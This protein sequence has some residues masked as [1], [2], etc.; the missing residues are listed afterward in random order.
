MS[1]KRLIKWAAIALGVLLVLLVAALLAAG[2]VMKRIALA[3]IQK[4]T[5]LVPTIEQFDYSPRTGTLHISGF[6]LHEHATNGGRLVVDLPELH[7]ELEPAADGRREL[8]F[9]EIRVNLAEV[10]L[11]TNQIGGDLNRL[12]KQLETDGASNETGGLTFTGIDRLTLTLGSVKVPDP[13]LPGGMR[14][15]P[16]NV[17][18]Q[19]FTNVTTTDLESIVMF[20]GIK[21]GA[22]MLLGR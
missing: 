22:G 2:P 8:R 3:G 19:T 18:G 6:R 13:S 20:L 16:M 11:S 10:Y 14:T 12:V 7:V 17:R 1:L 9:R 4:Q 21:A 5:G 15:I